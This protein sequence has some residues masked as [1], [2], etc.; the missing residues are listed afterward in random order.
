M[1]SQL[2]RHIDINNLLSPFQCGF[3]KNYSCETA[4]TYFTD[5][6]RKNA[7]CGLLTGAIFIDIKKAFDTVNHENLLR[8]LYRFGLD[9]T[10][11]DWF[12]NYLTGRTQRVSIEGVLSN[13]GE[14]TAGV[15][16]GSILGPLL[17]VIYIN[18]L[19][20]VLSKSEILMYANDTVIFREG[21]E[22]CKIKRDLSVDLEN[23]YLWFKDNMLHL[24]NDK[25]KSV[26]F[27]TVKRLS[28]NDELRINL[29]GKPIK[30][31]TSYKYLGVYLDRGSTFIEHINRLKMK[32][33]KRLGALTRSRPFLTSY[34][35]FLL[36]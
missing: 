23:V 35:A 10:E 29:H 30:N 5:K 22:V 4:V 33:A 17:F 13:S 26:L 8:K 11:L 9:D 21:T 20:S 28:M 2:Y 31:V 1:H 19:P 15:P 36:L 25:T 18:D 27:G 12:E 34:A 24:H 32:I 3:R 7:D 16:Q 6:I 14:I